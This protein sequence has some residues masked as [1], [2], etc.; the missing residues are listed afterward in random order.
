MSVRM[1]YNC[2]PVS[3]PFLA[4]ANKDELASVAPAVNSA[5]LRKNDLLER[6]IW[7]VLIDDG[8]DD[9]VNEFS[10]I[11]NSNTGKK[12]LAQEGS[13]P[14]CFVFLYSFR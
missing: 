4:N 6:F 2:I 9:Q 7:L 10:R 1:E 13:R 8:I 12:V 14:T 11:F 3:S 5:V